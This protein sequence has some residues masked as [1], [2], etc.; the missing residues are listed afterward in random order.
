MARFVAFLRGVSPMNLS[1]AALK[2][3]LEAAGFTDVKTVLSSGNAAFTTSSRSPAA[4]TRTIEAAMTKELGRTF[5]VIVRAQDELAA[6]LESD[7]YAGFKLPPNAKRVVTFSRAEMKPKKSLPLALDTARILTAK[8]CEAFSAYVP[9]PQGPV[10]M[11]LIETT[12][13]SDVTTRTWE[14]VKKC[15]KA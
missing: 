3:C 8:G 6:L 2:R 12:F 7:P 1:M 13:G 9:S 5:H 15:A 14:T 11:K 10:F 4:I